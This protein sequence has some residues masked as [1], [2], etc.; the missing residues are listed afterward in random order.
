VKPAIKTIIDRF[1]NVTVTASST[2]VWV[3]SVVDGEA[4]VTLSRAQ[5][6]LTSLAG[7]D[8]EN[9]YGLNESMTLAKQDF[10][11]RREAYEFNPLTEQYERVGDMQEQRWYPT[12]IALT[13]GTVAAVSGLDGA[14]QVVPGV[15]EIYDPATRE[16]STR[17][18]LEQYFPT[19][20]SIFTTAED[21]LLFYTGSNAGY[22]PADKGRDPGFWDLQT[23]AFTPV[24][25]LRD[26][27][28]METSGSTWAGPVQNQ[29]LMVVGGGA[30]G[31]SPL[32]T[33]RID[34]IDLTADEP[35]FT[36]GPSLK[37]GT[38]YPILVQLPD[39]TTLITGGSGGYRGRGKSHLYHAYLYHPETN[40]LTDV[41]SPTV[42]RDYHSEGLLL[43]DGRVIVLGSNPLF[44][45]EADTIVAPFEQRIEIYTPA[46]LYQPGATRPQI[47]GGPTTAALGETL[48]FQTSDPE[49]IASARLIHPGVSTH[50]TDVDQRS[51]ALDIIRRDGSIEFTVPGNPGIMLPG[52]YMLFLVSDA[53]VPSVAS[54][55]HI[56]A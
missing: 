7:A 3:E 24:P 36:P 52:P 41:A 48:T 19:Y 56:T 38:R 53:G 55:V 31:D 13:D 44:T 54:W 29:R 35:T 27:D 1:N 22:G 39:D 9:I 14:G 45:D 20:P 5:Y 50:V 28:L 23:N 4:G 18:E 8:A 32:S 2:T 33:A 34:I 10:Q 49:R 51:V 37:A 42:G 6:R 17:P 46:Y 30:V 15:T 11:G 43:P 12:L 47:L 25:G 26:P 40:S 21:D 16:W